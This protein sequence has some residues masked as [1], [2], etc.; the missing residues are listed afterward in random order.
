MFSKFKELFSSENLL[1]SAFKTTLTMMEF[2]QNMFD[3]ARKTLRESDSDELP[4]DI[5][6]TDRKINK[7]ERQ[8]RRQ[9]MTHLTIAGTH[10]LAPGMALI[11]IVIDVERIGDYTKNIVDL[12][13]MHKKRLSGG[14]HEGMLKEIEETNEEAFAKVIRILKTQD[15]SLAREVMQVEVE[16]GKKVEAIIASIVAG[17]DKSLDTADAVTLSMYARFLKRI[18]AHL[19]N[20]ASSIVNP[21]PR[22]GFR[23]KKKPKKS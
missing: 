21:F 1:D 20:I 19:T 12:A 7:F 4:F 10:N 18:N 14:K 22:I 3:A 17:K 6:K 16:T 11:S 15:K 5:R 13:S 2:D 9:V 8:V 23:E